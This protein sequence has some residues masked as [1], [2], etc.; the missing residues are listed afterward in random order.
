MNIKILK[1]KEHYQY[2]GGIV[3]KVVRVVFT[4]DFFEYGIKST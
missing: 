1:K 4:K 2:F 3:V